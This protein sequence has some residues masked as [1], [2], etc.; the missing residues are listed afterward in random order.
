MKAPIEAGAKAS[1]MIAFLL[2]T[3]ALLSLQH[4]QH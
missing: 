1:S 2:V 3:L 4:R